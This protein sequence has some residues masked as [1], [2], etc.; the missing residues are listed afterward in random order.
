MKEKR[1][2]T[3][4]L[5]PSSTPSISN[6]IDNDDEQ[7]LFS[8]SSTITKTIRIRDDND[9]QASNIEIIQDHNH[10]IDEDNE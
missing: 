2:L 1:K 3:Q 10:A 5:M 9:N 6:N 4:K 8:S 7:E